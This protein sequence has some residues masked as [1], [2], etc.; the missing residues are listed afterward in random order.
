MVVWDFCVRM[1]GT[2]DRK[3]EREADFWALYDE[4]VNDKSGF[5][6]NRSSLLEAY[7]EGNLYSLG[8]C[9][10]DAMRKSD[11]IF[12]PETDYLLPCLCIRRGSV[13]EI[14]WTHT[15]ARRLGLGRRLVNL[16][17]IT[18]ARRVMPESEIFWGR[19]GFLPET[20]DLWTRAR[21]PRLEGSTSGGRLLEPTGRS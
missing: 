15:R 17:G 4:L 2:T 3:I 21:V 7:R 12:C 11:P 16:L 1:M 6:A 18:G 10:T 9:E 8:V 5:L 19:L 20:E 13:A 14:V